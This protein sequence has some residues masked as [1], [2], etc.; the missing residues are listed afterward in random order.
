MRQDC[1]PAPDRRLP[2]WVRALD[3]ITLMLL[4]LSVLVLVTGGVRAQPA[5]IRLSVTSAERVLLWAIVVAVVRHVAYRRVTLFSRLDDSSAAARLRARLGVSQGLSDQ[6]TWVALEGTSRRGWSVAL[7]YL[8]VATLMTGLT[9][10]MTYPQVN[11]LDKVRDMGDPLFSIWRLSWVAHQLPRDPLHLFDANIFYPAKHTLALSDSILLPGFL[12]APLLWLGVSAVKVYNIW[13]L[14]SF[15]LSGLTMYALAKALTGQRIA[16]LVAA[17]AF[18]FYPFR[19]EHYSH[20]ELQL[21][22]WMPLVLLALHRAVATGRLRYGRLAGTALA[23]QTYSC[24]YFAV[25]LAVFVVP[26]WAVLALGGRVARRTA[27]PLI[28]GAVIAAILVMPLAWQ[29]LA[30]RQ[31]FGGRNLDEVT[32]Y[33]ATGARYLVAHPFNAAWGS[34]QTFGHVPEQDLFPGLLI[35][36]LAVVGLWPPLRLSRIAYASALLFAFDASLGVHGHFYPLLY[37]Y[38]APF[39]SIRVPAR[40][41]MLVGLALAILAG[42]GFARLAALAKKPAARYALAA[43]ACAVICIESRPLLAFQEPCRL[44]AIY[45]WFEGRP[46]TVIAE[47]PTPGAVVERFWQDVRYQYL[48]TFHWHNLVNGNSGI[49]PASYLT[50]SV[51]MTTF[52]DEASL[53]LLRRVGASYVVVHEEFYDDR[54]AYRRV[55]EACVRRND[56]IEVARATDRGTEARVYELVR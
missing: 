34:V 14:A 41:S 50:F 32:Y 48:S 31:Q 25:F 1:E 42:Y 47:L 21:S 37:R 29:Y 3:G 49:L 28:A 35:I 54:D 43:A 52:P 2:S 19:F 13:F 24:L 15:V 5:G 27:R 39:R 44:H 12:G 51:Q 16:A 53:A 17:V 38:A 30:A 46:T 8:G 20:F 4:A 23:A 36:V 33:S 10:V 18:A 7:E 9:L 6:G 56:L 45:A 40:L 22:F 11:A 26:V 55:V